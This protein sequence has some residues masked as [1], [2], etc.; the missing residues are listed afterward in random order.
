MALLL[1]WRNV[2]QTDAMLP[3]VEAI[4]Q[5]GIAV[6]PCESG[7]SFA[8][9]VDA[10]ERLEALADRIGSP[11]SLIA[12]PEMLE[13]IG[14]RV[15]APVKRLVSRVWPGSVGIG[16]PATE[17]EPYERWR[18]P[19]H[20]AFEALTMAIDF[21]LSLVEP[22]HIAGS[23]ETAIAVADLGHGVDIIIDDGPIACKPVTWITVDHSGFRVEQPGSVT[24]EQLFALAAR[25]IVFVCTGNTCRSPMAEMLCKTR[26]AGRLGCP[27]DE[28]PARG[29]RILSAGVAGYPGD[30]PSPEAV[31]VLREFGADLSG[32]RSQPLTMETVAHADYLIGMTRSHLL[33][34]LTRY[35]VVGGSLR[36]LCGVEGDLDDPIGAGIEVYAACSRTIV[37]H[38]D[39]LISELVCP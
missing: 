31:D 15:S 35:P 14:H 30:A 11:I 38:V 10:L 28:L 5:G 1:D 24:E 2:G 18:W 33:S 3:A 20:R 13:H 4:R 21:P 8:A 27:I 23:E 17:S 6:V 36:L 39:R 32:H 25:W 34:V 19:S 9:R 16:L 37:R 26:L 7:Y 29:F 22:A 12:A